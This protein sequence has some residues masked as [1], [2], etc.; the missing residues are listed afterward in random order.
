[1]TGPSCAATRRRCRWL[2]QD[3]DFRVLATRWHRDAPVMQL[4]LEHRDCRLGIALL[5]LGD[6]DGSRDADREAAARGPGAVLPERLVERLAIGLIAHGRWS[7]RLGVAVCGN[8]QARNHRHDCGGEECGCLFHLR[9]LSLDLPRRVIAA[10]HDRG[11][12]QMGPTLWP[13]CCPY[14]HHC[15]RYLQGWRNYPRG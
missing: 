8:A 2:P 12:G 5:A 4:L 14:R 10:W 7:G 15:R 9:F 13:D 1:M 6:R 3:D 11:G